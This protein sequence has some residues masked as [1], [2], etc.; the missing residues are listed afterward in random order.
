M[1]WQFLPQTHRP[2][3][4]RPSRPLRAASALLSLRSGKGM[5]YLASPATVA[6]SALAGRV[7]DPREFLHEKVE[8]WGHE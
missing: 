6:A 4:C 7:A 3:H 2:L 1:V 5:V 8:A